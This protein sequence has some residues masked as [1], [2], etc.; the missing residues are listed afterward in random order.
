MTEGK[1]H[2]DLPLRPFPVFGRSRS[3]LPLPPGSLGRVLQDYALFKEFRPDRIGLLEILPL[4]R[5]GSFAD[6]TFDLLVGQPRFMFLSDSQD[7]EDFI[8]L[9]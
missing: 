2:G 6:T 4:F 7:T 3:D 1:A 5:L 8:G 9:P